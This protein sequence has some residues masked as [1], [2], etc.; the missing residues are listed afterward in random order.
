MKY[1]ERVASASDILKAMK[2][3]NIELNYDLYSRVMRLIFKNNEGTAQRRVEQVP[4][5]NSNI[6]QN[7]SNFTNIFKNTN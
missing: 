7:F 5:N 6:R 1:Q 4:H 3:N 2:E